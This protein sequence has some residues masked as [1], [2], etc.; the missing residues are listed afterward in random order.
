MNNL[1]FSLCLSSSTALSYLQFVVAVHFTL[2]LSGIQFMDCIEDTGCV[3]VACIKYP[4][5]V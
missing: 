5:S 4:Y 3:H 1:G 2:R